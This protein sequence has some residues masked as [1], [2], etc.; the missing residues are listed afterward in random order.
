VEVM[1]RTTAPTAWSTPTMAGRAL[2]GGYARRLAGALPLLYAER[3]P[4]FGYRCF[5]VQ[6]GP[7]SVACPKAHRARVHTR[8]ATIVCPSIRERRA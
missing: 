3:V 7:G 4:S 2:P 5:S 6:R 1:V 8:I